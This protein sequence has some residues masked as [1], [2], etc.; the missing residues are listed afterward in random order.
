[1]PASPRSPSGIAVAGPRRIALVV[2][3]SNV[4]MLAPL[5]GG[6]VAYLT[7]RALLDPSRATM[8]SLASQ[9]AD[10]PNERSLH[11]MPIP[12]LGGLGIMAG[13]AIAAALIG[14]NST[15]VGIALTLTAICVFDDLR[16]LPV[17]LRFTAHTIAAIALLAHSS[18][19]APWW[20]QVAIVVAIVWMTNL[21]NFMDGSDGLAGGM[22]LFGF[23][24]YAIAAR[25]A[26]VDGLALTA[27]SIAFAAGAFLCLNFHPAR[28]FMGDAGS[29][30]LGFL[31]AALG[32][33]GY[34][35]HAWPGWFPV[36]VFSPFIVD[37]S[38]T[39]ARRAIA[40]E[41][42][43]HAHRSHYYQRMVRIGWG[44]RRVALLE[45][46]LMACVALI[47]LVTRSATGSTQ[48]VAIA[49][50]G[51][52]YVTYAAWFDRRWKQHNV[53]AHP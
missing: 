23:G 34:V 9:F 4:A 51:L 43:W 18:L 31:A 13:F 49:L 7:L 16:G 36:L 11:L 22:A 48:M 42:I 30:P 38:V 53:S 45:Y 33:S 28:V 50:V 41:R 1:M 3:S 8:R 47:A 29:I 6:L 24:T 19:D 44:H 25:L 21:F 15:L 40:G 10:R 27:A 35:T 17:V 14:W 2:L 46:A 52:A 26:G 39:L 32:Y 20:I 5:I 12:R 37:A